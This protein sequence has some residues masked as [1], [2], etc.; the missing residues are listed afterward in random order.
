MAQTWQLLRVQMSTVSARVGQFVHKLVFL[1]Y[2][3][4]QFGRPWKINTPWRVQELPTIDTPC[5]VQ[6]LH[7]DINIMAYQTK[8]E[9]TQISTITT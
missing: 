3:R 2:Y 9:C 6:E 5:K 4:G 1:E 7:E 8:V